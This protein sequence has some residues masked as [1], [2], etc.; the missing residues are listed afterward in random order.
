MEID[1]GVFRNIFA[2]TIKTGSYK[3]VKFS[4]KT[5]EGNLLAANTHFIA[6]PWE[7][8]GCIAILNAKQFSVCK[9]VN[10]PLLRGHKDFIYDL[11]FSPFYT[12]LLASTSDD[13]TVRLWRIPEE[14]ITE[15]RK[16][17]DQ[18]YTGHSLRP[19][20][21]EFHPLADDVIASASLDNTLQIW[22]MRKSEQ[23]TTLDIDKEPWSLDWNEGGT[24]IGVTTKDRHVKLFDPRAN[25]SVF[26]TVIQTKAKPCKMIWVGE[27]NFASIGFSNTNSRELKYWDIRMEKDTPVEIVKID[28]NSATMKPFYDHE[29]KLLYVTGKSEVTIHTF[30]FN[31]EK[32]KHTLNYQPKERS[33]EITMC[34]RKV[35]DYDNCEI[36]K[37]IKLTPNNELVYESF[38]VFRRVY[39][40]DPILYPKVPNGEACMTYEEW[41]EGANKEPLMEEI[42]QRNKGYTTKDYNF[43]KQE[44][45]EAQLRPDELLMRLKDKLSSL[46][47]GI[48][49]F[50]GSIRLYEGNLEAE[51]EKSRELDEKIAKLTAEL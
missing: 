16:V 15:D 4:R 48:T 29:S 40:Y 10:Q 45:K 31:Y 49:S 22:N 8:E 19:A 36:D 20:F 17:E 24:L 11:K 34:D 28:D 43:E 9:E 7:T 26:S 33:Q 44:I 32:I 13:A 21:V 3:K 35:I 30:D 37:F 51:Q 6:F 18:A 23:Y 39:K 42:T 50:E 14:G 38:Y 41:I 1:S 27:N 47:V 5:S 46:K 12:D 2:K 25:K